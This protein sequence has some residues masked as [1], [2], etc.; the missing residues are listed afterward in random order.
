M[1]PVRRVVPLAILFLS[2]VPRLQAAPVYDAAAATVVS[3]RAVVPS[4]PPTLLPA[5][6]EV[7]YGVNID[8]DQLLVI[9]KATAAS[10]VIGFVNTPVVG[11]LAYDP[12][13]DLLYGTDTMTR[14]L[15]TI[16]P[17]NGATLP[18]GDTGVGLLHGLARD[19]ATGTLYASDADGFSDSRL[20]R[21][22]STTGVATLVGPIGFPSIAALDFDP[23]SGVLYGARGGADMSGV[24]ITINTATGAGTFVAAT[25]RFTGM[26]FDVNGDLYGEDNGGVTDFVS[27]LFRVDKATGAESLIG[28]IVSGNV[29]AIGF[30]LPAPVS[31]RA[32][33]WAAVKAKYRSSRPIPR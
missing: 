10:A 29:L 9:D 7:L 18:V 5:I 20:W 33:T 31:A 32:A 11:G 26:A 21:L 4:G 28:P 16:V 6:A 25:R 19:P 8:T 13:S 12:S 1:K 27:R 14:S 2:W 23:V 24:L 30:N 15:V 3:T 17:S 22:D